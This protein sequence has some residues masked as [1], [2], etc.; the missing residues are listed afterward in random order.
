MKLP[1]NSHLRS[2]IVALSVLVFELP[3][4][5]QSQPSANP[6]STNDGVAASLQDLQSQVRELQQMVLELQR[7]TIAGRVELS[8]LRQEL[9]AQR[10][11]ASPSFADNSSQD[12]QSPLHSYARAHSQSL[13]HLQEDQQLLSAKVDEQYQTKLESASKYRVRFSG[14]VLLN[15]F[16]NS[17]SVDNQDVPTW[18]VDSS[19]LSSSG[20]VGGT[21]RQSI[22]GFEVFGPEVWGARS[23]GNI[24]FDF[25]G[26]FPGTYNGVDSGV[27]RLRTGVLRLDWK[28]TALVAGQDQLFFSPLTPTSF[29]SLVVP[30]LSYA[31]NLW[32][33]TPQVR[34]QHRFSFGSDSSF[35]LEGGVLDPL[36]GEPPNPAYSYTWYRSADA[37]ERSRTPA[38]AARLAYSHPLFGETLTVGAGGYYSRQNYGLDRTINGYAATLDANLPL[39]R[40]FSLSGSFYRGQAIGGIGAALGRSVVFNGALSNAATAVLPI[41]SV[42]GWAQLKLVPLSKVELNAAFGLDNPFAADIRV[43]GG[44]SQAYGY[45]YVTR[46][47][48]AF[49]NVIYRP[50]SDLL[51]S[52]Q[53]LRLR[54]FSINDYSNQAGQVN[55]SMGILF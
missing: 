12:E 28:N 21:L 35:T 16:G 22:L 36:T 11:S 45:P 10:E 9:Q 6:T 37:G 52:L 7:Q 51:L 17:G 34:V 53:Y 26:G 43:F 25:G 47:R 32:A 31:G 29:A 5:P 48:G 15:L 41:N 55:L 14:M 50:R 39:S 27:A 42:G 44:Q 19:P 23:S 18:A 4:I 46:N 49:G 30:P 54:T 24:N 2:A 20:S 38:F 8:H 3:C 33:W 1:A 13:D 40:R